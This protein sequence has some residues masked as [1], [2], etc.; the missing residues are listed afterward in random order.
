LG[1]LTSTRVLVVKSGDESDRIT[2]GVK[3]VMNGTLGEYGSLTLSQGVDDESS[4]VL[5]DEPGV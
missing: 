5:L 1:D 3:L 2:P 4:A